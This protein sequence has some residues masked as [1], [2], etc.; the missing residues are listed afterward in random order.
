M[1]NAHTYIM[2]RLGDGATCITQGAKSFKGLGKKREEALREVRLSGSFSKAH[3][4]IISFCP[5]NQK[6]KK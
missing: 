1:A 5:K 3:Y 6:L 2:P 4:G